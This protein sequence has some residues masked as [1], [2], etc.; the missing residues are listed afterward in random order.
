[1]LRQTLIAVVSHVRSNKAKIPIKSL[2]DREGLTSSK[3]DDAL[4]YLGLMDRK[5]I[6]NRV[7]CV[8]H[9]SG[10]IG[11]VPIYDCKNGCPLYNRRSKKC[12]AGQTV[13]LGKQTDKR[14]AGAPQFSGNGKS[15]RRSTLD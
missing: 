15:S 6:L 14:M 11:P 9:G 2:G 4:P 1:M 5:P 13:R 10:T 8:Q 7:Q 12:L 3:L